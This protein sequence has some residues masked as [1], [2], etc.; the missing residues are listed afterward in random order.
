M[1]C[2]LSQQGG[3]WRQCSLRDLKWSSVNWI[4]LGVELRNG[5]VGID[6][7]FGSLSGLVGLWVRNAAQDLIAQ[8]PCVA[9]A[10]CAQAA[11]HAALGVVRQMDGVVAPESAVVV[12]KV[13][14]WIACVDADGCCVFHGVAHFGFAPGIGTKKKPPTPIRSGG[15][16]IGRG[17]FCSGL[18]TRS[19][20]GASKQATVGVSPDPRLAPCGFH[21]RNS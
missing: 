13:V 19:S 7:D 3:N 17:D 10:G 18:S 14:V 12:P 2:S 21:H 9:E 8:L 16:C 15:L 6:H 11:A 4:K 1:G 5:R 20:L